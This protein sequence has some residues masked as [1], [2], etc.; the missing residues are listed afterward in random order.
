MAS[1]NLP[2]L[3][4]LMAFAGL[5]LLAPGLAVAA[6]MPQGGENH[7]PLASTLAAATPSTIMD[8]PRAAATTT[9]GDQPAAAGMYLCQRWDSYGCRWVTVYV[10]YS[11]C[12]ANEWFDRQP[13]GARVVAVK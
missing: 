8:G 13:S 3:F 5:M 12:Q 4:A 7:D 10:C 6:T 1:K 11:E 9:L 2:R